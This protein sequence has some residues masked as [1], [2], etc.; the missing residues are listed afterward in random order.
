MLSSV[1]HH[2][3]GELTVA[4]REDISGLDTL[5][6]PPVDDQTLDARGKT[7]DDKPVEPSELP[8]VDRG[9]YDIVGEH[10]RGGMGRVMVAWDRRLARPVAI[11]ELLSSRPDAEAR[12]VREALVTARLQHPSIVPVHEAGRWPTGEPFYTMKMVQGRALDLVMRD[13]KTFAERLALLPVVIAVAEAVAYAHSRRVIHRDLKP[14]NVIVGDFG[15]TILI[16]WG[17]AK[18]LGRDESSVPPSQRDTTPVQPGQTADG[19]VVGTPGFMSPEQA[20]GE[21][22][23]I[24]SDVYALGAMLYNLLTGQI[25]VRGRTPPELLQAVV[26]GRMVPIRERAPQVPDELVDIVNKAMARRRDDRY[27]SAKELAADLNRFTTGQL[28]AAHQYSLRELVRRWL[29]RHRVVVG[30]AASALVVVALF[31][32][33]SVRRVVRERDR[34][35]HERAVAVEA[36]ARADKA[37]QAEA[38]RV[39][40]LTV[41][42]ARAVLPHDPTGTLAWLKRLRAGS[43]R[44]EEAARVAAD[45]QHRGIA[46]RVFSGHQGPVTALAIAPDGQRAASGGVD[47]TVRVWPLAEGP[48]LV[49]GPGPAEITALAFLPDGRRLLSADA[50]GRLS[51]WDLAARVAAVLEGHTDRVTGIVISGDG[52]R[53]LSAGRDGL[54]RLWD[55]TDPAALRST[56]VDRPLFSIALSGDG[57]VTAVRLPGSVRRF[58]ALTLAPLPLA[59]AQLHGDGPV[60]FSADGSLAAGGA[61]E[62]RTWD[63]HGRPRRLAAEGSVT[64]VA[65]SPDGH[66]LAAASDDGTVRWWE[67]PSSVVHPM[68]HKGDGSHDLHFSSDGLRLV[69]TRGETVRVWVLPGADPRKLRGAAD[70]VTRACFTPDGARLVTTALDGVVRVYRM[71]PGL[72]P[73]EPEPPTGEAKLRNWLEMVTNAAVP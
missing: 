59:D 44:W 23:D 24:R 49:L 38:E 34:A 56:D 21:S 55:L 40:E 37:R 33:F 10:G 46:E 65:Y 61:E 71:G 8:Q 73:A 45:A 48:P 20:A 68:A 1:A 39:D 53:A 50:R 41:A 52:G 18:E 57:R 19:S 30:T 12:F 28:V 47:G 22:V 63:V 11:K 14:A 25:P 13:K 7:L 35:D 26:D 72:L 5:A 58:D 54:L 2:E 69:A 27:A 16:D 67:L 60:T 4:Q 70:E 9:H 36:Q 64:G 15:E 42:Q 29:W 43:A 3:R 66:R 32:A 51:L 17:L 62:V 6:S 31:G